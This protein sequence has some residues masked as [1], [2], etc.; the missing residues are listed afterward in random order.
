MYSFLFAT[1][2]LSLMLWGG[3]GA[4]GK[5]DGDLKLPIAVGPKNPP[6]VGP[7]GRK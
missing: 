7:R 5:L 1:S 6:V 4:T 2:T 3:L